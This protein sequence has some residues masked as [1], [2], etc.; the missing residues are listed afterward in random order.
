VEWSF[1]HDKGHQIWLWRAIDHESG[2]AV[3]FWFV[4]REHKNPDKLLE[5]LKPLTIGKEYAD[6]NYAYYER[7]FSK[8]LTITKKN[9]QKI[10]RK[11]LSL[12]GLECA[13]GKERHTVLE[14]RTDA[15]NRCRL[16]NKC[17][18]FW[19]GVLDPII[20]EHYPCLS[21]LRLNG[22]LFF[23]FGIARGG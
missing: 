19:E 5:L 4:T 16:G 6:G 20:L 15:Q 17:L 8:V 11:Q 9:T 1:Y 12:R 13:L 7:F 3:A 23:E 14:D 18:V 21:G 10:E 22:H 2:E